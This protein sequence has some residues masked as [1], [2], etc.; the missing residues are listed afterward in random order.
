VGLFDAF[1]QVKR[2]DLQVATPKGQM[3]ATLR[4]PATRV[5]LVR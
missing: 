4:R 2:I 1:P 3:K 5:L